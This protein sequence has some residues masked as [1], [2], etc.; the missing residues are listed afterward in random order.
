MEM[1]AFL[2]A[3]IKVFQKP[4]QVPMFLDSAELL[5][6]TVDFLSEICSFLLFL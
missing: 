6:I 3:E 1:H 4:L 5:V 2:Y